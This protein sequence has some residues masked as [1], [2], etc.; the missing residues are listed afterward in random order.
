MNRYLLKIGLNLWPP[1]IGTGIWIK[2][3]T[4]DYSYIKI[5]MKLRPWNKNIVGSH[6]GGSLYAMTDPFY[7]L[8]LLHL[9]G[10]DYIVW[11]KSA[12]INF[13]KPGKETVYAE[14]SLSKN[15]IAEIKH[16]T[17]NQYKYEPIFNILIKNKKGEIIAEVEKEL[18]IRKKG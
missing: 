10:K 1:F 13:I 8:M 14:F 6:F 18:Y 3:I 5:E 2:E 7:M 16:I 4:S 9:L 15:R 11:D 17:E 12:K